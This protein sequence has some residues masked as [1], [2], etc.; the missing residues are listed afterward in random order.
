MIVGAGPA[1]ATAAYHLAK[2]GRSVVIVEAAKLPRYKPCGGG[3]SPAIA[4]YFDFDL[5]PV[6]NLKVKELRYT[7]QL[8]D[9]VKVKLQEQEMLIVRR[10]SFDQFLVEQAQA[11]GAI[12]QDQTTVT[13]SEWKS[14]RWQLH[15]TQDPV[16]GRYL[17][18]ADGA[19]GPVA[20][21]LK[22]KQGKQRV[23]GILEVL[24]SPPQPSPS[25]QFDF[26]NLKNGF[27]WNYP[28]ADGY[29]ICGTAFQG[30]DLKDLQ[31]VL[32]AYAQGSGIEGDTRQYYEHPLRL[33]DGDRP[34]HTQNALLAGEAAQIIDPLS[35]EGIRP[36]IFTAVKA[37]EAIDLSLAGD[38][39]ALEN[40]SHILSEEWGADMKWAARISGVFYKLPKVSY[41]VGVKQPAASKVMSK[42]LCGQLSYAEVSSAAIKQLGS[43]LFK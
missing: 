10:D 15:T 37:A 19:Q 41:R 30:G 22:L 34:L 38:P 1:G 5:N 32:E 6:V 40:Y 28:K 16:Q 43:G 26:G 31:A 3:V 4:Q 21:W 20:Q 13:G 24:G 39:N 2:R 33:W 14:D 11:Q 23:A 9:A 12:L 8:G 18:A 17:I 25:L 36:S 35:G 42:I 27:I 29:S 7:W